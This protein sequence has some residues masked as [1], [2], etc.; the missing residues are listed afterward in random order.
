MSGHS[1]KLPRRQ[2]QALA[3]LLVAPTIRAAADQAGLGEATLRRWLRDPDFAAAY[4]EARY[5]VV[6]AAHVS[7][8]SAVEEAV[9][10][11]RRNLTCGTPS[12]EVRAAVAV[13]DQANRAHELLDLAGRVAR[14]EGAR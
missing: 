2:E 3:A 5:R 9:C 14:L 8:V 7:L 6:E 4:R 11:L 10:G 12:V 1:G 13:L